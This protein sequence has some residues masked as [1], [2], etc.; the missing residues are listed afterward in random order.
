M[1][2][3]KDCRAAYVKLWRATEVGRIASAEAAA[4]WRDRNREKDRQA[5]KRWVLK[6][7]ERVRDYRYRREYGVSR[8]EFAHHV[9]VCGGK[10]EVCLR[11]V[12]IGARDALRACLDHCH[13]T[14][15]VRGVLCANCNTAIGLL[16]DDHKRALAAAE[17]LESKKTNPFRAA[18]VLKMMRRKR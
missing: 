12:K 11:P 16:G 9:E 3:C 10:C 17:Y 6:N 2:A 1:S 18:R 8:E 5:S 7:R 4:R 15:N 14:G 13:E